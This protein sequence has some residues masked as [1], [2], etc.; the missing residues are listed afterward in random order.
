METTF[1]ETRYRNIIT[2]KHEALTIP[3][4][5]STTD[6]SGVEFKTKWRTRCTTGNDDSNYLKYRN[7]LLDLANDKNRIQ[8][9]HMSST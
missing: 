9:I 6:G 7:P 5:N 3:L 4:F 2:A 8:S 1:L